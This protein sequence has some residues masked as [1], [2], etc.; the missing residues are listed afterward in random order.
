MVW[1]RIDDNFY[2]HPKIK[3]IPR[4]DRN[5]ALALW[6]LAGSWCARYLTDGIVSESQVLDLGHTSRDAA[7]LV[8]AGLW[9]PIAGGYQFHDWTTYQLTKAQVEAERER[10]RKRRRSRPPDNT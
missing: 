6:A 9:L 10:Q 2:D 8:D 7:V 5:A 1:F 4:R 3:G